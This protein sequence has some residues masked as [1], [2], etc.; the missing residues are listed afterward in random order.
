MM[1]IRITIVF[2]AFC[3]VPILA[4][5]QNNPK[6]AASASCPVASDV[7]NARL[8]GRWQAQVQD[9]PDGAAQ[10]ATLTLERNPEFGGSLSGTITRGA[11]KAQ[12]AGDVD[13][14]VFTLEESSDG[15]AITAT[16]TGQIVEGSCGREIRGVWKNVPGHSEHAFILRKQ[17]SWQ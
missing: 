15:N 5:A 8:F 7:G 16:W 3:V 1:H 6:E 14:G 13:N 10:Q 11:A 2:I 12:V 9:G 17:A 4:T